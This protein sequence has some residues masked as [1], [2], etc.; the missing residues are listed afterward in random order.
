MSTALAVEHT[1][2]RAES[3]GP[4]E[5]IRIH[6]LDGLRGAAALYVAVFHA[7]QIGGIVQAQDHLGTGLLDR[8]IKASYYA[9]FSYGY[10]AVPIFIVLSGYSLMLPVARSSD[11]QL[12]GGWREYFMRRARRI[13]PPYYAALALS[14]FLIAV[15]PILNTRGDYWWDDTLPAFEAAPIISHLLLV[16]NWDDKWISAINMPMW[17]V[18]VEWQIYFL[19]PS[20]LL[21]VW[22]RFGAAA[23]LGAGIIIGL[24]PRY[25]F[26][27]LPL[28]EQ[29][30]TMFALGC[31]GACV[32]FSSEPR[33]VRLRAFPWRRLAIACAIAF[34]VIMV[35]AFRFWQ[36]S[37]AFQWFYIDRY[38]H[39]VA[40]DLVVSVGTMALLVYYASLARQRAGKPAL[41]RLLETPASKL[42]GRISYSLYLT[43]A[44]V[45]TALAA[46]CMALGLGATT[47]YVL[48]ITVGMGAS[49]VFAWGFAWVFERPFLQKREARAVALAKAN[50]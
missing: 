25:L 40:K 22:R 50:A 13:L 31:F 2:E 5:R 7:F 8:A 21:P 18:A 4:Q 49:I 38:A 6:F 42:L 41:M 46:G 48:L 44:P 37:N 34:G 16:H 27:E 19:L 29:F 28:R 10:C 12:V 24:V 35:A 9:V 20:I 15:I 47:T 30:V 1:P 11:G 3:G 45:L 14:L 23:L 17:S 39:E 36:R 43:H 33:A 26:G 32:G